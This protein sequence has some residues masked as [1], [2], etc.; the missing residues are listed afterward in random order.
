[1]EHQNRKF[2]VEHHH[3]HLEFDMGHQRRKFDVGNHHQN[4][5]QYHQMMLN[6]RNGG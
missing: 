4:V 2:D 3:H 6:W 5:E 1:M